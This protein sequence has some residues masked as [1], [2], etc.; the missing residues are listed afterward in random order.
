MR[1][2]VPKIAY[3]GWFTGHT[4][5]RDVLRTFMEGLWPARAGG[6]GEVP[7]LRFR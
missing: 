3:A 5:Y 2:T 4:D 1:G 6:K 7:P